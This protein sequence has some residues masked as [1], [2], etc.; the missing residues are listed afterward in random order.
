MK[1]AF[2]HRKGRRSKVTFCIDV[3]ALLRSI[4][5]KVMVLGRF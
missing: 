2:V 5:K 4:G 3:T 1:I